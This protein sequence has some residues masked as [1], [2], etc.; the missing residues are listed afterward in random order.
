M[1][2]IKILD[3]ATFRTTQGVLSTIDPRGES[4]SLGARQSTA[5]MLRAYAIHPS[6]RKAAIEGGR[7][8]T[9]YKR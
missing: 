1:T 6:R 9:E 5:V 4:I 7:P 2:T 8:Y 3:S